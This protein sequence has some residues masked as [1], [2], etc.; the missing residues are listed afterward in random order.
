MEPV[1]VTWLE[2]KAHYNQIYSNGLEFCLA[3]SDNKQVNHLAFCKDYLQ[4]VY[5]STLNNKPVQ[6]YGLNWSQD[7]F[8][9]PDM[10]NIKIILGDKKVNIAEEIENSLEF[11]NMFAQKLHIKKSTVNLIANP[12]AGYPS[13]VLTTGS[14]IWY[15]APPLISLYSLLWRIGF[16]HK[17]GENP[18]DT[19]KKIMESKIKVKTNGDNHTLQSVWPLLQK[20]QKV[21]YRKFFYIDSKKN[22]PEN[23]DVSSVHGNSGILALSYCFAN[24]TKSIV[25]Y[26]T[27]KSARKIS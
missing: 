18:E 5:F 20:I 8:P 16:S 2:G 25:D 9:K 27:R 13:M 4:D 21:G 10:E 14:A 26:W 12:K 24:G 1:T 6:I 7:K 3:S 19:C 17:K 22:Y 15:N 23:L 11:V